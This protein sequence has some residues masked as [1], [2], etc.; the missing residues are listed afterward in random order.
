MKVVQTDSAD[1]YAW[2]DY[3]ATRVREALARCA[4]LLK[5]VDTKALLRDIHRA[6]EQG[7]PPR[8]AG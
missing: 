2:E 6:R 5:E 3:D 4:G 7:N 1:V 8:M